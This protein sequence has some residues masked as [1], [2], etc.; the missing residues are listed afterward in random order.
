[1]V[2]MVQRSRMPLMSSGLGRTAFLL[3]LSFVFGSCGCDAAKSESPFAKNSPNESGGKDEP[4]VASEATWK[5]TPLT[6]ISNEN[7]K[8]RVVKNE[9]GQFELLRDGKPY[10]VKGAG[11]T[12]SLEKLAKAGA[13]TIRTWGVDE[14]TGKLLDE[15][16]KHGIAVCVGL[17]LGH[18]RHG[19][20]YS[21]YDQVVKQIDDTLKAVKKYKDH[22]A[23]LM[24]GVGNEMEGYE[25]GSSPAVW[26]HVEH[27]CQLI[28]REDPNHPTMTVIAEIGGRKI[29]A[30]HRLAPSIDIVGINSYG[31]V[32][33]IPRRYRKLKA[34]KPYMVTEFGPKGPWELNKNSIGSVDE[35][36]SSAK[37]ENYRLAYR[38]LKED[39][40][41]CLGCF[42]FLWGNKQEATAT[43]FGMFLED[44][45]KTAAVDAMIEEWTGKAPANLCPVIE[46]LELVGSPLLDKGQTIEL[47][48]KANDPE[49]KPI[50]VK[51]QLIE[52][53][54]NYITGGDFQNKPKEHAESIVES[55]NDFA[56]IKMPEKSGLYRVYALVGDGEGAAVANVVLL[57][58]GAKIAEPGF[59]AELPH[60][61]AGE[62]GLKTPFVPTGWMGDTKAIKMDDAS[63]VDPKFGNNCLEF[64]FDKAEG[65]GGVV[66]QSPE[67]DWGDK[68][69]GL[70]LTGATKLTFW[71]RGKSGDEE[72]KFG[73]GL[74]GREKTYYDTAKREIL[75]K[76]TKEW[77]QYTIKLDKADLKRIKT[78]FYWS[79]ESK[80]DPI[81]FYVDEVQ[82]EK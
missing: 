45:R 13:N 71:A 32:R 33:S 12:A 51:W 18:E 60:K 50:Q 40:E 70:D 35:L 25:D 75:I 67:N 28:K 17:W 73:L 57:V 9:N 79:L 38:T 76:L 61:F 14:N 58:K 1:M 41:Y 49:N 72:V 39:E 65:W 48:L 29:E 27:L 34:T 77:R 8:V 74:L 36:T 46:S 69:G 6:P 3:L 16:H 78:G 59:K 56:K 43:W 54:G 55:G 64:Q 21:D 47:K 22:P 82:Y 62:T 37:A 23:L 19:F 15:A 7:A 4:K 10:F 53:P 11:G 5:S 42:A 24:W 2:K 26:S 20:N 52:D 44:G 66:W 31:G 63:K 80:G 68:P 30:L 81:T